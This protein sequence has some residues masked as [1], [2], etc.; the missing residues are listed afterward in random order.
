MLLSHLG[1]G[2]QARRVVRAVATVAAEGRVT[3]DLGG[4]LGTAQVTDAICSSLAHCSEKV[5]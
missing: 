5:E 3:R 1:H 2:Q 4:T